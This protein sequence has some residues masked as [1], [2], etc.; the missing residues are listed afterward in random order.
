LNVSGV[1]QTE[2]STTI[3]SI[4]SSFGRAQACL[5]GQPPVL[6]TTVQTFIDSLAGTEALQLHELGFDQARQGFISL[7]R[8]LVA[9]PPVSIEDR[10]L[11]VGPTGSVGV[12]IFR[13]Q[14]ANGDN[15]V[16]IYSHGGCWVMGGKQTH[17]RLVR[18]L[19]IGSGAAIV[20]V[21][22]SPAPEAPYPVQNEQ[23]YAVLQ[24]V[25][26]NATKLNFDPYRIA[27]AGDCAGGN[28]T[29]AVTLLAKQRRGPEIAFQL[30]FYPVLGEVADGG[31]YET[32]KNGPW[33]TRRAMHRFL[34]AA[35]PDPA[36]RRE[37]TAFPLKA[38][39]VQLNDLPPALIIVPENDVV[40]D[41]GE[42]YVRR[43]LQAGVSATC[44]RYSGTIHD[45]VML[46]GLAAAPATR[47]AI[48]Q[49]CTA[50]RTA[51]YGG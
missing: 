30:L 27:V 36:R 17:D 44:I 35:F 24:Y 43:L 15:P 21:D 4:E 51:L 6:E 19:A 29:A 22:Y 9:A 40:R 7:Q 20:F 25:A 34:D 14:E 1:L 12:R 49:A 37:V 31:S 28:I 26:E 13:P 18:E 16:V 11:P 33:L 23:T 48:S 3:V 46:N 42:C 50:L 45:F 39:I 32:F 38:S 8:G 5:T 10:T 47:N 41:D 2:G